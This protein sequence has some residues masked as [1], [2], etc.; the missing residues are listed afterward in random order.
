M[1]ECLEMELEHAKNQVKELK[2]TLDLKQKEY[3][4]KLQEYS[5][6]FTE[7]REKVNNLEEIKGKY[8][9]LLS[10]NP[11]IEDGSIEAY[12]QHEENK[13]QEEIKR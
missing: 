10:D 7:Y 13:L 8:E 4:T 12:S 3:N 1:F 2:N 9:K 6:R 5:K 11:G